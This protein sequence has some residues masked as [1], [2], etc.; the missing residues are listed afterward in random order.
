LEPVRFLDPNDIMDKTLWKL[1]V[2]VTS[3]TKGPFFK[4]LPKH[5]CEISF[6]VETKGDRER[7]EALLFDEV[8]AFKCTHLKALGSVD[9][10]LR[11][12]SYGTVIS[13]FGSP[14]LQE[15]KQCYI[16]YCVSARL[17]PKELQHLM[18]T[19]DDGPCYE[20][21]CGAFKTA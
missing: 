6:S 20:F 7:L 3:I 12:E 1:P 8:E 13:I 9:K 10:N 4:V 16:D 2:P 17:L 14:W 21:I 11:R 5:Q 18:I 15:V 19:F